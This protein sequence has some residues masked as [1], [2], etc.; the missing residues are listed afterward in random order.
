[1][2]LRSIVY[3]S[4]VT[5]LLGLLFVLAGCGP[6]VESNAGGT[7]VEVLL[8]TED[9]GRRVQV[10]T[11]QVIV[12]TLESNPST[13]YRW[14]VVGA[15]SAV[16]QQV[17]EVEFTPASELDPPPLGASG[18]EVYRFEAVGAG[19]TTLELVYHRPWE[20]G[21]EPLETFSVEVLVR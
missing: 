9:H 16:L 15:D 17:G 12:L 5:V 18:V 21:V 2:F 11:S 19:E 8:G 3:G 13:G 4:L 20:E 1:V 7:G 6:V 14:E 10:D